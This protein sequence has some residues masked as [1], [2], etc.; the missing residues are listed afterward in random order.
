MTD[1]PPATAALPDR[2]LPFLARHVLHRPT[3]F[4]ALLALVVVAS[5]CAVGVQYGMKLIVDAMAGGDRETAAVW[6]ALAFFVGL[7]AIESIAWR[8]AGWLSC[9][10]IVDMGVDVRL[11]LFRHLSGHSLA[12]FA[13]QLTGSL[14]NRAT[15]TAGASAGIVLTAVWKVVPPCV[16]FVGAV[17]VIATIDPWMSLALVVFVAIVG[18]WMRHVG[19]GARPLQ[20]RFA[21]QAARVGGELVDVVANIATVKAFAARDREYHRLATAFHAEAAMQKTS[22]LYLEQARIV[23]DVMLWL[24]AGGMLAWAI[25]RWRAGVSEPGSVVLISTLTFRILHG[26][27]DLALSLVDASQQVGVIGETLKVIAA[28]HRVADRTD[29]PAFVAGRGA[30]RFE[31]VTFGYGDGPPLF[32]DFD[33]TIPA[34]QRVGIVG[35]SGSGKTTLINLVQ[36]TADVQSGRITIDGQAVDAVRQDTLRDAIAV[37]PQDPALFHRPVV[38][39]LR[40]G[41]PDASDDAVATVAA[42]AG[43]DAFVAALV[44]GYHTTVGERGARLSGGQRQRIGIGRA[45]LKDA[46]L[47]LLDEATSA[48]DSQ[49]EREIQRALERLMDGR[50]VIAVAHRLSTV[51][52]FDRIVVLVDGRIVE[53]GP[54]AVL[55]EGDGVYARL[56]RLQTEGPD[57]R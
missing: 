19:R 51:A 49:S 11:D 8:A 15:A 40:Y 22:W 54:P 36:R 31:R 55:R 41:R 12:Y 18:G 48:L 56:W 20:R 17:V 6:H 50:T 30:V 39:N 47:L 1:R 27:R 16:D 29:A 26:S 43:A 45:L 46:P 32:A 53:D 10:S 9:I 25:A 24:M 13:Q 44:D 14:G 57:P 21:E 28:P 7:I 52:S 42:H 5:G 35:P 2:P 4:G 23:H 34:G 37:V 33:L 3:L 38:D